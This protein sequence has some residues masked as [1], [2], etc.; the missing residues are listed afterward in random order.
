MLTLIKL[1]RHQT[2]GILEAKRLSGHNRLGFEVVGESYR[3]AIDLIEQSK[4]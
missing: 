3:V 2:T 1:D 4:F